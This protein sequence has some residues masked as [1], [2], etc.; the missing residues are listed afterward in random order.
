MARK[1]S[2]L[3]AIPLIGSVI[4]VIKLVSALAID[5]ENDTVEQ[6]VVYAL[7]GLAELLGLGIL[8]LLLKV[9][10]V[11]VKVLKEKRTATPAYREPTSLYNS[12]EI[13]EGR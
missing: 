12:R 4:G 1:H 11:M 7:T 10:Y 2:L 9:L 6:I 8:L 5:R 3:A 13:Y